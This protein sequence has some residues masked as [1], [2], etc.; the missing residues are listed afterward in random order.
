[1]VVSRSCLQLLK[2]LQNLK[3]LYTNDLFCFEVTSREMSPSGAVVN[4]VKKTNRNRPTLHLA[5]FRQMSLY[6]PSSNRR[7]I[8]L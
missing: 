6:L 3:T 5:F 2:S 4:Y 8:L 1:M 7:T